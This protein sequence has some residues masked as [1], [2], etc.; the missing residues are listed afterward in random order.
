MSEGDINRCQ[1]ADLCMQDRAFAVVDLAPLNLC[2]DKISKVTRG[3]RLCERNFFGWGLKLAPLPDPR[4][5]RGGGDFPPTAS[6]PG[7]LRTKGGGIFRA[8]PPI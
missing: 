5:E 1:S 7:P 8:S 4:G 3:D 2:I 6:A